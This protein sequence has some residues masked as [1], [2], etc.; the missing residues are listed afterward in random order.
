MKIKLEAK[1]LWGAIEPSGIAIERH[2]DHMALDAI[3]SVVPF[4]MISTL[5]VKESAKE[6][7]E[8]IRVMQIGDHRIRKTNVQRPWRQYEELALRDGEGVEDFAL[9]LTGIINQLSTLGDPED[10]KKVVEKYLR[11]ARVRY[12]HLVIS[13]QTLL[14]ISM[15]SI[16]E[17][18]GHLL[19]SD[20]DPG[21]TPNQVGGKLYLT[22]E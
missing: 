3:C 13:M 14:N 5:A 12:K 15:L 22:E 6:T 1:C 19:A 11:I 10:P 2:E 18:T 17:V 7:W 9:H 21:S 16:E 8:S 4:E 20:D